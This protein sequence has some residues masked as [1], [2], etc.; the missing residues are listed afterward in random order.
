MKL[1]P[2]LTK[3]PTIELGWNPRNHGREDNPP[4]C[5]DFWVLRLP[6]EKPLLLGQRKRENGQ[7]YWVVFVDKKPFYTKNLDKAKKML[8]NKIR[9]QQME[10]VNFIDNLKNE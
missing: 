10:V 6:N 5:K 2:T 1:S 7:Y 8:L 9:E 3:E 4:K